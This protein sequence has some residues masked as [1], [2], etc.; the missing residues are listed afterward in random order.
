MIQKRLS[1]KQQAFINE[2]LKC[3][4]ATQAAIKAGYSKRSARGMGSENLTKPNIAEE[5]SKRTK[6]MCM[7]ADEA[8]KLLAEQA[9]GTLDD[10]MDVGE[11]GR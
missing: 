1:R 8:L 9:R 5:I 2:Y 6:E 7:S 10:C 4:N 3:S 11:D